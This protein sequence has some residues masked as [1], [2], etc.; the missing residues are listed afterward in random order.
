MNPTIPPFFILGLP[1]SRTAWLANWLTT[2]RSLCLHDGTRGARTLGE[3]YDRLRPTPARPWMGSSGGDLAWIA[4]PLAKQ[5]P[6]ARWTVIE[7]EADECVRSTLRAFP[8]ALT[9]GQVEVM[10]SQLAFQLTRIE[11]LTG[12]EPLRVSFGRLDDE[13]VARR[14]WGHCLP[15]VSFDAARWRLLKTLNVQLDARFAP[16]P[17]EAK[18][19]GHG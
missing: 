11:E 2:D 3:F 6:G 4:E 17:K 14:L 5:F 12:E 18:C 16:Q 15:G 19:P 10:L 13:D 7:R 1:R 9:P 8:L